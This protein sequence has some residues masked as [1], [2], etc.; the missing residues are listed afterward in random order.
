MLTLALAGFAINLLL[1]V[2]RVAN[3]GAAIAGCGGGD[4]AE[5]LGS[6]WAVI[7][8]V[9]VTVFGLLVY[10]GL[11]LSVTPHLRA[12]R[13]PLLGIPAGAACW[14]VFVQAVLMGKFCP[15]CMAAHGVGMALFFTGLIAWRE[16][17]VMK[18][19]AAWA[20]AAFLCI[21]LGQVYGPLPAGHRIE[22]GAVVAPGAPVHA[23]GHGRKATFDEGRKSF[24]VGA[25]PRLGPADARHVLI[26]YFDYQCAA[27]RT[28]SGF[29]DAL[30]ARHPQD[31]A[32]IVLPVPMEKACNGHVPA[33]SEHP[34]SCETARI[35]LAVWRTKPDAFAGFHKTLLADPSPAAARKLALGCLPAEQLAV[36]LTDSWIEE[37]IRANLDDWRAFS[38]S[39]DKL[40]K[41]LIRDRRILHGLPSGG[42]DFIRVM[43]RELGL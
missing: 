16:A 36:S 27:C 30:L 22:S 5:A 18:R 26:E 41:L 13:A 35:A 39:T 17:G 20:F 19:A 38:R 43:E 31:V 10:A 11:M 21:G 29:M 7:F 40:P 23:R 37:L 15:W 33:G 34:G 6:R 3:P 1:L 9:P 28:M 8:G 4:C 14:F 25:L 2:R 24:D 12:W 32:V 42:A